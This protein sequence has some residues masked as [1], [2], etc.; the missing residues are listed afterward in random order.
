MNYPF[1]LKENDIEETNNRWLIR[2]V[3]ENK[4]YLDGDKE[5]VKSVWK[6]HVKKD[7]EC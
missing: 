2:S 1:V 6:K 4:R 5:R 7:D 3:R